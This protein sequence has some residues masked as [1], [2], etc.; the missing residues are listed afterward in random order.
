[1]PVIFWRTWFA[2]LV[3]LAG[4]T[5]LFRHVCTI[6]PPHIY[7]PRLSALLYHWKYHFL[8]RQKFC[9]DKHTFVATKII[10]VAAPAND[11]A[12]GL[13]TSNT[14]RWWRL[15]AATQRRPRL[16]VSCYR[17]VFSCYRAAFSCFQAVLNCYR[18]TFSCYWAA[19][20]CHRAEFSCYWVMISCYWAVFIL[21]LGDS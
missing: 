10:L 13:L 7:I 19:F 4:F 18:V 16:I 2:L 1:M 3:W 21:L 5:V 8:S 17:A 14:L 15:Q 6:P 12:K 11:I 9:L 20:S